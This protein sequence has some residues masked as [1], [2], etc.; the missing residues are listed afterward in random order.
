MNLNQAIAKSFQT[1]S[2][3]PIIDRFVCVYADTA[4]ARQHNFH[5]RYKVFCEETRFEN[6]SHFPDQAEH[7]RYDDHARHFIVWDRLKQQWAGSMR[8]VSA[9]S[10]TLPSE[11]IVGAPLSGLDERR[12]R[13]VEFSRLCILNEYRRTPQSIF[14]DRYRPKSS[15]YQDEFPVL[16][17]QEDNEVLLRLIRA[18]LAWLPEIE[19]CYCIATLALSRVL[20]RFGIPNTQVGEPIEHRGTRIP[21]RYDVRKAEEGLLATLPGFANIV[22]SSSP[23]IRYSELTS[24]NRWDNMDMP[25]LD[26]YPATSTWHSISA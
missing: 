2:H 22:E 7:D 20:K 19:H 10:T 11:D 24:V 25:I 6:P 4:E 15:T 26:R 18:S 16:Y 21:F 1:A 12:P 9:T 17:R 14:Y 13:S 23:Y 8:L 3:L 5:V